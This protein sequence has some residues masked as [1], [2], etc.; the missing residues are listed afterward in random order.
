[1]LFLLP[2]IPLLRE[3]LDEEIDLS[4]GAHKNQSQVWPL[5][6]DGCHEGDE[7]ITVDSALMNLIDNKTGDVGKVRV[8]H[9]LTNK[10]ARGAKL[11]AGCLRS[12]HL[13]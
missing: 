13:L 7:Q 4:G 5:G 3:V 10:D 2:R 6:K 9:H 12:Q 8:V 1:M 11:Y